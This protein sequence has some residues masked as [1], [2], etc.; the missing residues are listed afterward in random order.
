MTKLN[1]PTK[2]ALLL[3]LFILSI[4]SFGLIAC[5]DGNP[6][7]EGNACGLTAPAGEIQQAVED[8]MK[9]TC[10][11]D[12]NGNCLTMDKTNHSQ[13]CLSGKYDILG[14]CIQ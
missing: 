7:K 5:D 11:K 8:A 12:A 9:N 10:Q 1:A 14:M 2:S 3:A 4:L 6:C 13:P